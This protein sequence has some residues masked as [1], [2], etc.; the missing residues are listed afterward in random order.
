MSAHLSL[1]YYEVLGLHP[2]ADLAAIK[3]AFRQLARKYHPDLHGGKPSSAM[4]QI[5]TAYDVLSDPQRKARYDKTGCVDELRLVGRKG[6]HTDTVYATDDL[7]DSIEAATD[8]SIALVSDGP[9]RA[10]RHSKL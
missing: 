9:T 1:N 8:S 5:S 2:G 7:L 3:K 10:D 4:V 6:A